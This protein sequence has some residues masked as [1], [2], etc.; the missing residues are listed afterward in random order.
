[1]SYPQ[2]PVYSPALIILGGASGSG[3]SYLARRFGAPHVELDSFYREI[4]DDPPERRLPRTDYGEVDWDH[5]DTFDCDHAAE[6][7]SRLMEHGDVTI[8]KYDIP[9]SS[10]V[11]SKSVRVTTGPVVAEG[12][13]AALVVGKLR[14]RG[15]EIEAWYITE[16]RVVTAVRRFARDVAEHR[17][18]I[19]HLLQRGVRLMRSESSLQQEALRAGFTP[20][21]KSRAKKLLRSF[22]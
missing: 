21:R 7:L 16:P 2:A 22:A 18:P 14:D 19:P 12:I 3:K 5:P 20:I 10:R 1:M 17:K 15:V 11:G 13:F 6:A 8:P 4:D 9:T